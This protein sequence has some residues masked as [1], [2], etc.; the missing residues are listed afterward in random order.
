MKLSKNK[1]LPLMVYMPLD[2]IA[3][4]KKFAEDTNQSVSQLIR[5]S[6]VSFMGQGKDNE[7]STEAW[8]SGFDNGLNTA[9][10]IIYADKCVKS[11]I[12][13][14]TKM[15]VFDRITNE[16]QHEIRKK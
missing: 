10:K 5:N 13:P 15:S 11:F 8:N 16:I 6:L 4:T 2:L 14:K 3:D 9:L 12:D 1:H 7:D